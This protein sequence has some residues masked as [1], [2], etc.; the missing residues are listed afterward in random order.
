MAREGWICQGGQRARIGLAW[1]CYAKNGVVFADDP[2]SAVD[3]VVAAHLFDR[4]I[5][6]FL[7]GRTRILATHQT[8]FLHRA[9]RVV[10]IDAGMIEAVGSW[11]GFDAQLQQRLI[12]HKGAEGASDTEEEVS[13]SEKR[14]RTIGGGRTK[15]DCPDYTAAGT[16]SSEGGVA[17]AST[18]TVGKE[19]STEGVVLLS[20]YKL[21][22]MRMPV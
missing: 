9:D 3:S 4:F 19:E 7:R 5:C 1:L 20:T 14:K 22:S 12:F 15:E 17:S 18:S 21:V 2:L 6:G 16:A 8:Q 13:S 10:V 11:D